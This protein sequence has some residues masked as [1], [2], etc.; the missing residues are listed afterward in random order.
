MN[1]KKRIK[2]LE[3]Q[4][5]ILQL[6]LVDQHNQIYIL[7]KEQNLPFGPLPKPGHILIDSPLNLSKAEIKKIKDS[8]ENIN[9]PKKK[10]KCS[11][12]PDFDIDPPPLES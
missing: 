12:E 6:T 11:N 9:L 8:L 1:T 3:Q 2:I 10:R 5:K 7:Q 4:V